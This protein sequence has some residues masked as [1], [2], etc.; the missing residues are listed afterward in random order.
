MLTQGQK[1]WV[2][3][4]GA[5]HPIDAKEA[6]LLDV[7][8]TIGTDTVAIAEY[9]L[10]RLQNLQTEGIG[11]LLAHSRVSPRALHFQF[12]Q[13]FHGRRVFRG[14]V[15]VN[16]RPDGRVLSIFDHTIA[17]PEGTE[18]QFPPH[19]AFHAGLT[20]HYDHALNGRLERYELEETFFWDGETVRPAI[21]LEVL[22]RTDRFYE[23]VLN[24]DVKVIYQ[25]DLITYFAPAP[26]DSL[27]TLWV[28]NPDPL[29]TAGQGYGIPYA[30]QND[31]DI[32]ELNAERIPVQAI[33]TYDN[34]TF[35]L[36]NS[37]MEIRDFSNPLTTETTSANN[38]FN[39]TR[40]EVGF[41]DC[42]TLY[43]I[44]RFR[45]HIHQ[46]G[47]TGL[48]DYAIHADAHALNGSDNSQFNPGMNPPS[49]AFGNG[50]VDDA[51]DADVIVHEYGHAIMHSAAPNSNVGTQRRAMDEAI[52]D[53]FAASYSRHLNPFRWEDVFTWD[54]HNEFWAGRSA[55]SD[56]HYPEDLVNNIYSDAPIW[57][58]TLMQIW[59]DIGRNATDAIM[60]QAAYSFS[61]GMTMPQ[62]AIAFLQADTLL[63]DGAHFTPIRQR[64]YDRGL[65][66]WNVSIAEVNRS[67][68]PYRLLSSSDFAEDRGPVTVTGPSSFTITLTDALG[69]T[70]L[71]D[72]TSSDRFTLSP[73]GLASGF[74]L[75]NVQHAT[76]VH[77]FKLVRR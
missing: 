25:N 49:L 71:Q 51:E 3:E 11:L 4:D 54:G 46:L 19:D 43:H 76:G 73:D 18:T 50:G 23:M 69:R 7:R 21:R 16:M 38:V 27:V 10:S 72:K 52:G 36:R 70:V 42:N 57:S 61:Q 30:D 22:E 65:I 1:A 68:N 63:F 45:D 75:L 77:S 60:L 17:I 20:V 13:T 8:P 58:A 47:F 37:A 14:T 6:V 9:L 41:E 74:Y 39:F 66:P 62:A 26:Q 53:Y 28:F 15:R 5:K 34:G 64:M 12:D 44:T 32:P 31:Q 33:V 40:S 48:M 59:G 67:A 2:A 29:T 24:A 55:V 56:K 35:H